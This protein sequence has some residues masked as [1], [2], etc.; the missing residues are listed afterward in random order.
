MPG[1]NLEPV[2]GHLLHI[3]IWSPQCVTVM[4]IYIV[5]CGHAC[6]SVDTWTHVPGLRRDGRRGQLQPEKLPYK[7]MS[8]HLNAS[9]LKNAVLCL[10][11]SD[12]NLMWT[13]FEFA[14]RKSWI[15][16]QVGDCFL[17]KCI[18]VSQFSFLA[19]WRL[20]W[21]SFQKGTAKKVIVCLSVYAASDWASRLPTSQGICSRF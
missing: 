4:Y 10:L 7:G 2:Y 12:W 17:F 9:T 14:R 20:L 19:E 3:Y 15:Q 1:E 16:L 21:V 11:V 5:M 6:T 18:E 13:F 8:C